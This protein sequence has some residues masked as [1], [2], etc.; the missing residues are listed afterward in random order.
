M[1]SQLAVTPAS[2]D[3]ACAGGDVSGVASATVQVTNLNRAGP[4]SIRIKPPA[5]RWFRIVGAEQT[6][7]IAPGLALTFE[8]RPRT[9][10]RSSR[11]HTL[12]QQ[13]RRC[14]TCMTDRM[15]QL[16]ENKAASL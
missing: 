6:Q 7:H 3:F 5:T 16:L 8:V 10:E 9:C 13:H 1:A 14:S 12:E 2:L 15:Q 4:L 11:L